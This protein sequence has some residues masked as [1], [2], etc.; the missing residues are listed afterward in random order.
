MKSEHNLDF[1]ELN[2]LCDEYGE[3]SKPSHVYGGHYPASLIIFDDVIGS[4]VVRSKL[5]SNTVIL[6]RHLAG[7][8]G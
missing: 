1:W 8:N 7:G 5:L 6:H 2:E 3:I 4:S